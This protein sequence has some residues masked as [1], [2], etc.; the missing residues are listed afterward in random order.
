MPK[1]YKT[2]NK[3]IIQR[4]PNGSFRKT[5]LED[6]G[7][8]GVCPDCQHLLIWTYF[9]KNPQ[10]PDPRETGYECFHCG[11]RTNR[12]HEPIEKNPFPK[13]QQIKEPIKNSMNQLFNK[14]IETLEK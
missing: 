13:S 3:R 10:M 8:G 9:G 12:R 11:Y 2:T 5:T 1:H 6:V 14:I 7:L 4:S